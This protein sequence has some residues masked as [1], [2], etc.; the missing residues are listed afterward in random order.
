[1]NSPMRFESLIVYDAGKPGISVPVMLQSGAIQAA[2]IAKLD[3]GASDCVFQRLVGE[4]LGLTIETGEPLR[5]HMA[6]GSFLAYGHFVTMTIAGY[7]FDVMVYFAAD[8]EM[9][10]NVLGRNGFLNRVELGLID[11]DGKLFLNR[12]Q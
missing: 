1:M 7:E 4:D 8:P 12:Y 3:T 5:L 6:I 11:Y 10:R 9:R 2:T